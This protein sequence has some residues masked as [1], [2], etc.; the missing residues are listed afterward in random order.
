MDVVVELLCKYKFERLHNKLAFPIVVHCVPGAGKSSLIRELL[1][2]D[3]RFCAYTA[4]VE[5][6]PRLS[7]NWIK[8]WKGVAAEG[9]HLILDEYTLLTE[10]PQ[11][12]ALFGDPIQSCTGSV[13]SAD[14]VCSFSRRFGSATGSL[15]RELGWDIRSEGPDLVQV[16]DVFVK[17]PEGVV[18][19]FEEEVG[20]LLK[21]HSVEA[22]S[23]SEIVGQT[24]EVV[25]FVTSENSPV[26]N[27][28]A[29][30]QCMTRH[31]VALH[32]LCPNATYSAA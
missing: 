9:K 13:R 7:G 21:A 28:A 22:F 30:Y 5:D 27:R 20:C 25:T 29:A 24:F 1:E 15:L 10:V 31:R 3:S 19:Y 6:Q 14:F 32:I 17:E 8:K 23:L 18:V 2:L 16:S 12:F 26:I 4:G 11:A